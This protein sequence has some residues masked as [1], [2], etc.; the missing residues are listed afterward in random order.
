M[1][2]PVTDGEVVLA[3][4][5][6]AYALYVCLLAPTLMYPLL[7]EWVGEPDWGIV[8]ATYAGL[9]LMGAQVVALGVFCSALT[10]NQ[11]VASVLAIVVMLGIWMIGPLGAALLPK[12]PR[13]VA[14]ALYA[15]AH[16]HFTSFISGRI[17]VRDVVYFASLT[18]LW[19]F[20]AVRVVE[21]RRWRR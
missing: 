16:G 2:A 7:L 8:V 9:L 4:F 1:T 12:V 18:W 20:L 13:L 5:L 11:I 15:G 14:L 10:A 6:G 17:A 19:L 21:S 3:K